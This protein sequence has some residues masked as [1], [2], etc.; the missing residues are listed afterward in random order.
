MGKRRRISRQDSRRIRMKLDEIN[1]YE[2]LMEINGMDTN[3]MELPEPPSHPEPP[4]AA[5]CSLSLNEIIFFNNENGDVDSSAS[6][7][8]SYDESDT[9][10]LS[11]SSS[12]GYKIIETSDTEKAENSDIP[13]EPE[14]CCT[15]LKKEIKSWHHENDVN[16]ATTTDLLKRLKRHPQFKELPSDARTIANTPKTVDVKSVP[17][18][19]YVHLGIAKGIL[20][21]AQEQKLK[22][23]KHIQLGINIDGLP[24]FDAAREHKEVWPILGSIEPYSKVF[25]IGVYCGPTKPNDP[26]QFLDLFVKEI[27]EL[28]KEG[29]KIKNESFEVNIKQFVCDTPAK[30]WILGIKAP[31][32]YCSC[33]RCKVEGEH[34]KNRVCFAGSGFPKRTDEE[35]RR[36]ADVQHHQ[37][38]TILDEIEGLDLVND[39]IFDKMHLVDGGIMKKILL[40]TCTAAGPKS[41]R[42]CQRQVEQ[43]SRDIIECVQPYTPTE[44]G[45]KPRSLKDLAKF[46][47]TEFRQ[48]LLYYGPVIF[49]K[50]LFEDVYNHF[51]LLHVAIR[52]L[53][54]EELCHEQ[55]HIDYAQLLLNRFVEIFAEI[56]GE[57]FVSHNV[58]G[59]LHLGEDVTKNE[60]SLDN[61][62]AYKYENYMRQIKK[63]A[64]KPD[65]PLQQIAKRFE[66]SAAKEPKN[67]VPNENESVTWEFKSK[68]RMVHYGTENN[69]S[70]YST[71]SRAKW[72]NFIIKSNSNRDNTVQIDDKIISVSSLKVTDQKKIYVTGFE[73]TRKRNLFEIGDLQSSQI[74]IYRVGA[75][76]KQLNS[77]L[78]KN[79]NLTKCYRMRYPGSAEDFAVLPLIHKE[80]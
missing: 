27:N 68:Y 76:D 67:K 3:R 80:Y 23:K 6:S 17:P 15:W 37:K 79:G 16:L 29:I 66:E 43:M 50:Y 77:Y 46:K 52:I 31:T 55:E 60:G 70:T 14:N 53:S 1:N 69:G 44:F 18:G 38:R 61:L 47:A 26:N 42:L 20:R 51:L 33:L 54:D 58:H 74:G 32:G 11:D 40:L 5:S 34:V 72:G 49:R 59:L 30:A 8:S 21:V 36:Y 10:C 71:Y 63:W 73:Y 9:E 64:R 39:V 24:I 22:D 65:K 13:G 7:I 2:N 45:R 25:P 28:N 19:Q 75:L 12:Y 78:V 4:A 62:S 56:Y 48:I 41:I 57:E 35:F